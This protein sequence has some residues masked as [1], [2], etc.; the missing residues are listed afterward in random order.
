MDKESEEGMAPALHNADHEAAGTIISSL[1]YPS[2]SPPSSIQQSETDTFQQVS[3]LVL[4]SDFLWSI[5]VA[6]NKV[7]TCM[8]LIEF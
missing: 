8:F 4:S 3:G 1:K 7:C 5:S 6:V 2:N